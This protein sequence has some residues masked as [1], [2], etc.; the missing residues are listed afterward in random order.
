MGGGE[1][2]DHSYLP[3]VEVQAENEW[4]HTS[5]P[6]SLYGLHKANFISELYK[7]V[8]FLGQVATIPFHIWEVQRFIL[9]QG[10]RYREFP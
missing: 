2:A 5:T 10:S 6:V 4:I 3:S 7:G 1:A 9:D 8:D